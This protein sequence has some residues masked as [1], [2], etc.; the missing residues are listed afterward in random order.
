VADTNNATDVFVHDRD[1]DANGIFDEPGAGKTAL[2]M[3]S[4]ASD[5]SQCTGA[6]GAA[7]PWLS[8]DAR[9]VAFVSDCTNF[10]L[11]ASGSLQDY[12]HDRLTGLTI[13]ES[14]GLDGSE[15]NLNTSVP[16]LSADGRYIGFC[17]QASNLIDNDTNNHMDMFVRDRASGVVSRLDVT[18][19][20]AQSNGELGAVT[21]EGCAVPMSADGRTAAFDAATNDLVT[22][23]NGLADTFVRRI[24]P[25]NCA[26]DLTGNCNL[27][28][29]V[30]EV[31]DGGGVITTLCPADQAAVAGG[32]VAFL[33]PESA[34]DAGAPAN[35]PAGAAAP[36]GV[37]L[38]GDG[39][40]SDEVVHVWASPMTQPTN[41]GVA[42]TQVAVDATCA[43]GPLVGVACTGDADCGTG[44]SCVP[45]W[46]VALVSEAG[47]GAGSLNGDGDSSDQ[48]VEVHPAVGGNWINTHM[49]ADTVQACGPVIVFLTP[50][51]D[52]GASLNAD[53]DQ[54]DRVLQLYVPSS[55]QLINTGWS[56]R[57]F[58]CGPSLVAFRTAESDEPPATD[59]NADG[60]SNDAVLQ[61]F[62]IGRPECLQTSHPSDC[63]I[64]SH[65]SVRPC[66][67]DACDP[68]VP[69]RVLTDTVRFLTEECDQHG[70]VIVGCPT[71]G[72]DMNEDATAGDLVVQSF[73]VRT[74]TTRTIGTVIPTDATTPEIPGNPLQGG[75]TESPGA[76]SGGVVY[77]SAGRCVETSAATCVTNAECQAGSYCDAGQC[78]REQGVCV[79]EDDCPSGSACTPDAIVPA[80]PDSDDDGVPD[81]IDNCP[82][83]ANADQ[84]DTDHDGAGDACDGQT[85]GNGGRDGAEACDGSDLG[86]CAGPCRPDCTCPCPNT[87]PGKVTVAI[88]TKKEAGMLS[89]TLPIA[90]ASYAG[91]PIVI[92]LDDLDSQPIV[93]RGL[94]TLA[95]LGHSGKS[96]QFKSKA[97]GLQKVQ[98]KEIAP[99][100]FKISVKTKGWFSFNDANEA[101]SM[102]RLTVTIGGQCFA[103]PATK[104]TD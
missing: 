7:G 103:H 80:S 9:Y 50:E 36:S 67:L 1:A 84:T 89:A 20:G 100:S 86:S 16:T 56:A 87:V 77:V 32:M 62:D 79:T 10:A 65:Q 72:T 71:G 45:Q 52:Q 6:T 55:G 42:A 83:V 75:D 51:A 13:R 31:M 15:G 23:T 70:S 5:G 8:A 54:S 104:K 44:N 102:T 26:S 78:H 47:Q 98:L 2:E 34:G 82:F 91:E 69:Y 14:T 22:D 66:Q 61:V 74:G 18:P 11:G 37:D 93:Q 95:P 29:D 49:A 19:T 85:C 40:G 59:L 33:R 58:A 68:L 39:D 27:A 48:V 101:P 94:P 73:N 60:D 12:V 53:A 76:P 38:N 25:T 24:D 99:G 88:K 63:V 46:I 17:S 28:D 97:P 81:H 21:T 30:L 43:S 57:D 41:L 3:V 4:V 64:T 92:R 35:C 90:L 96:W